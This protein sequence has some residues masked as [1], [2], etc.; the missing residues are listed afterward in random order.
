MKVT[1]EESRSETPLLDEWR[2][3]I[4]DEAVAAIV[5]AEREKI[6]D[7]ALTGFRDKH[8]FLEH[9]RKRHPRSA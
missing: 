1:P 3:E 4:G 8:R 9:L 7:G 5:D 2:A 6:A